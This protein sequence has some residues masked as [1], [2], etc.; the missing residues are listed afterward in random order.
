[1]RN[2][3]TN[4]QKALQFVAR[5]AQINVIARFVPM[6]MS[7][8]RVDYIEGTLYT[9][10][11]L[12]RDPCI[13]PQCGHVITLS[14]MDNYMKMSAHYFMTT[15]ATVLEIK[16]PSEPF[17]L[18]GKV[19]PSCPQCRGSLRN[20]SRYGRIVRCALLDESTKFSSWANSQYVPLAQ[21]LAT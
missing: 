8:V 18:E 5:N 10:A 11:E 21:K 4:F 16:K 2:R 19:L 20:I 17:S 9:A 6:V 1:M 13:F 7:S 12:D 3:D 14:N 15:A